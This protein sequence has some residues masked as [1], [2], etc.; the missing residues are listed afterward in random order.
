MAPGPSLIND[1]RYPFDC[2]GR[3]YKP[4]N[5]I[6]GETFEYVDTQHGF[7]SVSEQV[8]HHPPVSALHAE[9]VNGW[10]YNHEYYCETKFSIRGFLK[11]PLSSHFS[12]QI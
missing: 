5:P 7:R 4:F 11:V 2:V 1:G 6:L 9:S 3:I 12:C 8:C 10:Q